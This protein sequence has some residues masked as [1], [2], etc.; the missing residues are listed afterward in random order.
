MPRRCGDPGLGHHRINVF[1]EAAGRGFA[2]RF[3]T[4]GENGIVSLAKKVAEEV[5]I[6]FV[7]AGEDGVE[8]A[9]VAEV[10]MGRRLVRADVL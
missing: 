6:F 1:E 9:G 4:V 10:E 3:E 2:N 7:R 5:R 8:G